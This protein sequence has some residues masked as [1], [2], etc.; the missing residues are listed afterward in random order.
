MTRFTVTL[1]LLALVVL[2]NTAAASDASPDDVLDALHKAASKAEGERYFDLFAPDAIF[3]GTDPTERWTIAQFR[4]YA[5]PFF[6]QGQGWTYEVVERHVFFGP[7]GHVAWFDEALANERYGDCRGTGV[8]VLAEGGWKI[9]Q[10]NLSIPIPNDL[11][12][13]VV[14][15]IRD[16][17]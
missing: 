9:A 17:E 4:E 3:F 13:P 8:L 7:G 2:P 5:E 12:I 6:S 15:M 16:A 10:Y 1:I 11:A 14:E